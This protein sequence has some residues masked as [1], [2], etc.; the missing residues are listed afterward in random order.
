MVFDRNLGWY[1][2]EQEAD[3]VGTEIM[4]SL[5]IGKEPLLAW[6]ESKLDSS[7]PD[8]FWGDLITSNADCKELY[9]NGFL[10]SNGNEIRIPHRQF[11][12]RTPL[13][14]LQALQFNQRG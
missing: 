8:K 11:Y 5:G 14:L 13:G 3:E 12:Q 10:D 2:S 1:T 9:N 6:Y 4:A 7:N